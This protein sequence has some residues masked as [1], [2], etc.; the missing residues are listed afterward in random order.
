MPV[1]A[2]CRRLVAAILILAA[3]PFP[4]TASTADA[5][6]VELERR[7]LAGLIAYLIVH[8]ETNIENRRMSIAGLVAIRST[9]GHRS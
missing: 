9:A 2:H 8:S 7:E 5:A 6:R 1:F 3:G 4:G